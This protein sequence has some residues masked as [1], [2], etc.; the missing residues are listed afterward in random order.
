MPQRFSKLVLVASSVL[1]LASARAAQEAR[2]GAASQFFTS[3]QISCRISREVTG[4]VSVNFTNMPF[5]K[6]LAEILEQV[7]AKTHLLRKM[8][9]SYTDTMPE[10]VTQFTSNIK[11][12][13]PEAKL[14]FVPPIGKN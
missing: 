2:P 6:A 3:Q 5:E 7:D 13:I 4:K 12:P 9:V 8:T 11:V 14:A 1:S 10:R